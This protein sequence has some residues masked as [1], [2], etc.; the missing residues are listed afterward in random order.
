MSISYII[1][2][3]LLS[4]PLFS[5]V[6]FYILLIGASLNIRELRNKYKIV[7][8]DS[9]PLFPPLF[10]PPLF[11]S[12]LRIFPPQGGGEKQGGKKGIKSITM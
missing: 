4:S 12:L 9:F 6:P 7:S 10:F 3:P 11:P 1:V 2:V 8:L 5:F